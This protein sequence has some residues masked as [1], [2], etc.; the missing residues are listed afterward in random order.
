MEARN[1]KLRNGLR[2][3]YYAEVIMVVSVLCT[4]LALIPV[5]GLL[6]LIGILF[7]LVAALVLDIMGLVQLRDLHDNYTA[8]L[9]L[10]ILNGILSF[11][12]ESTVVDVI[13]TVL[14]LIMMWLLIKTTNQFLSEIGRED[15]IRLGRNA[16]LCNVILAVMS[17]V[18]LLIST[19]AL[20]LAVVLA[21]IALIITLLGLVFYIP[22]LKQASQAF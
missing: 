13:T 22:Y 15:V 20:G 1:E 8:A 18:C 10:A 21:L 17:I 19:F 5:L 2:K 4:I 9:F 7:A 14:G 11:F 6:F 12:N 16:L 3:L